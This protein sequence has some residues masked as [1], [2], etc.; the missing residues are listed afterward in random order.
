METIQSY[1]TQVSPSGATSI[2]RVGLRLPQRS[3]LPFSVQG[4]RFDRSIIFQES[5]KGLFSN[6]NTWHYRGL[7]GRVS[8]R[9]GAPDWLKG[10]SEPLGQGV[11]KVYV[12][13]PSGKCAEQVIKIDQ[14]AEVQLSTKQK[15]SGCKFAS[16]IWD[17]SSWVSNC[18]RGGFSFQANP[19]LGINQGMGYTSAMGVVTGPITVIDSMKALKKAKRVGDVAGA[20]LAQMSVAKGVFETGTGAIMGA[21]RTLSLAGLP[22]ANKAAAVASTVLGIAATAGFGAI[23]AIYAARFAR[24]L[25]RAVPL[26]VKLRKTPSE[27]GE[28]FGLLT[29]MLTLDENELKKCGE[30]IRFKP[31]SDQLLKMVTEKIELTEKEANILTMSDQKYVT[32]EI[33]NIEG[34]SDVGRDNL[35]A[36]YMKEIAHTKMVKEAEYIRSVGAKSLREIKEYMKKAPLSLEQS[37]MDREKIVKIA[38]TELSRKV[39]EQSLLLFAVLIGIVSFILAPTLVFVSNIMMLVMNIII[40]GADVKGLLESFSALKKSSTKEKIVIALLMI[41]TIGIMATG[42]FFTGGGSLLIVALIMGVAMVG[43]QGSGLAYA[44]YKDKDNEK[45]EKELRDKSDF[46]KLGFDHSVQEMLDHDE[47]DDLG[48]GDILEQDVRSVHRIPRSRKRIKPQHI[49]G[50]CL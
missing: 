10:C 5:T 17:G 14:F 37:I 19:N 42:A 50:V 24:T 1:R 40:T 47:R 12:L 25:A 21:S 23:F 43:I 39:V 13:L 30:V 11:E 9:T 32:D 15:G 4:Q 45:R 3:P 41:L 34:L 35:K 49:T 38:Q 18:V 8:I 46:V 44:W 48:F 28:A 26:L 29:K 6:S 2:E 16:A 22:A 36:R 20:K 33:S 27:G 7:D 31:E